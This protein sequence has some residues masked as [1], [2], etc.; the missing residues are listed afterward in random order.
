M[1]LPKYMNDILRFPVKETGLYSGLPFVTAMISA[2]VVG[3]SV[4]M[5]IRRKYLNITNARK[6]SAVLGKLSSSSESVSIHHF[7]HRSFVVWYDDDGRL[8]CRM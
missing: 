1:N 4:D 5:I 6:A 8:V 3:S 2:L 7:F